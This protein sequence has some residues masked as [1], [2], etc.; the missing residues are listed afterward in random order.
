MEAVQVIRDDGQE[1]AW[2]SALRQ[3]RQHHSW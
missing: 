1:G 3:T 2:S